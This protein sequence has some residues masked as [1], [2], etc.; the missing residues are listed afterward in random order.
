MKKIMPPLVLTIICIIVSGVL[1]FASD[2]TA[3]KIEQAQKNKLSSSLEDVF[4]S[5]DY[6][7]SKK[8]F[9]NVLQVITDNKGRAIFDITVDGYKKDG[10]QALIG[11]DSSGSVCGI[12]I[13][14]IK[15]TTGLGTKIQD[16]S[17]IN[18]YIGLSKPEFTDDTII[19]GASYS[20]RGMQSAVKIALNTYNNNKEAIFNE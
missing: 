15:E 5:A 18:K 10:I 14:S 16:A 19:T 1:A 3:P 17:Y 2:L 20:S 9:K 7:I 12:S 6:K 8:S 4:G 13:V 11:I